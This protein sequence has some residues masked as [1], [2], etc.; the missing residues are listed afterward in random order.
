MD[1]IK[2]IIKTLLGKI[3]LTKPVMFGM[4]KHRITVVVSPSMKIFGIDSTPKKLLNDF[5]FEE[6]SF[7][8]PKVLSR[9]AKENGYEITFSAKTPSMT[10]NLYYSF[11]DVL[12]E[13]LQINTEDLNS[14]I[15]EEL[16]KSSLPNSVKVWGKDNPQ[17]FI[18]NIKYI[19]ELLKK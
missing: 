7:L 2:D 13:S 8:E 11:G 18:E 12:V 16:S 5:P 1:N 14:I 17:K 3:Y 6:M 19:Q 9:W 4:D 10:K 15:M